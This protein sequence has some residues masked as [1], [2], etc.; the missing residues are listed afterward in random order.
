MSN[1]I[2]ILLV[3]L[4]AGLFFGYIDPT[5]GEIKAL[6]AEKAEYEQA[7]NNSRELQAERDEL[8]E[9][10]NTFRTADL[11]KLSKLLPD[12]IDNV[13]LIIDIDT[14]AS[15]YGMRVRDF[16]TSAAGGGEEGIIGPNNS[17]YGTITLAFS[18]TGTYETFMAFLS[19][20]E[21]SLRL[22]DVVDIGFEAPLEEGR[23]AAGIYDYKVTIRTYWL[24]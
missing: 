5:Y 17:P 10:L 15:R 8:L 18:T 22:I 21:R 3:L 6:K 7:L 13:R 1:I 11:E 12:N 16:I 19:D 9:K 23:A 20:L 24:K 14:V 2:S 4:S